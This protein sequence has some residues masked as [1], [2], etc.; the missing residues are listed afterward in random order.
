MYANSYYLINLVIG[1]AVGY[2]LYTDANRRG[3]NGAV[4]G[5][6]GFF[7]SVVTLIIYLIMRES[8]GQQL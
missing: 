8:K 2:Y 5:I 3:K 7:F 4:W 1:V 6:L